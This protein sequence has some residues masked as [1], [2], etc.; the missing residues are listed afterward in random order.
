MDKVKLKISDILKYIILG[1]IEVVIV[2]AILYQHESSLVKDISSYKS[3]LPLSGNE[4][5]EGY[6]TL[7]I[8]VIP[9]AT[10]TALY[11][12]GY[13]TQ[14][15]I[16]LFLGG[17]ILGT[18]ITEMTRY[19]RG[20]PR[21]I[22]GR[23]RYPDWIHWSNSP[24]KVITSFQEH[25]EAQGNNEA[26][27]EFLYSGQLFQGICFALIMA[28]PF[29]CFEDAPLWSIPVIFAGLIIINL[30]SRTLAPA[31]YIAALI[32]TGFQIVMCCCNVRCPF[33]FIWPGCLAI[34]LLFS[35]QLSKKQIIRFGILAKSSEENDF[36][37]ILLRFG[38]PDAYILV[39]AHK[40]KYLD[41]ALDSIAQQDYP[42]IKTVV[43]IDAKSRE[44]ASIQSLVEN[45]QKEHN[46]NI[47]CS[48]AKHSGPAALA[49]EIRNIFVKYATQDDIAIMLD[50][51]DLFNSPGVVTSI[52]TQMYRS[53]SD[54]CLL[55]F[56]VFG[57]TSLNYSMN[58]HNE[59]VKE[60]ARERRCWHPQRLDK[61][62]KLHRLSTIGWTKCYRKDTVK[63]YQDLLKA[64][65]E[66]HED[67]KDVPYEGNI[68]YEDFPDIITLLRKKARICAVPK[69]SIRFRK[70]PGSVTT[71]II[72]NNYGSYIPYFLRLCK[73]FVSEKKKDLIEGAVEIVDNRL[74]P[75]KITQYFNILKTDKKV[76][77]LLI[78]EDASNQNP[79][80]KFFKE[81]TT[82]TSRIISETELQDYPESEKNKEDM[83]I[84]EIDPDKFSFV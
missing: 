83:A 51:D 55:S 35:Y 52:M 80:T 74:V 40:K 12:I 49:Y 50:S 48:T 23:D 26:K 38:V 58:R 9:I 53:V 1:L 84:L 6:K 81:C 44:K 10:L 65:F 37:K 27:A 77:E 42:G 7:I 28:T 3:S 18:G 72:W 15:I 11:L 19:L 30:I 31:P 78:L 47:L 25:L 24:D 5:D 20:N 56:E 73:T 68:K 63:Y 79:E 62:K 39:R 45:K 41:E 22:I 67:G 69:T 32:V 59:L 76:R 66:T 8:T 71:S 21:L 29:T 46:L 16:L 61:K 75:Y 2:V 60:I 54:I 33:S 70:Y 43:L 64:P 14:S 36:Q 17:Q 82:G 34:S 57:Q 4:M 13:I